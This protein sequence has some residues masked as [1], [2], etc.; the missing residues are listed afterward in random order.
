MATAISSPM[1]VP[2]AV[3]SSRTASRS[4][5]ASLRMR[6]AISLPGDVA[7]ATD[8][9]GELHAGGAGGPGHP[10]VGADVAVRVD[11]DDVRRPVLG[12]AE[13]HPSVVAQ[14]EG[15]EGADGGALDGSLGR[16]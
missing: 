1:N 10:G 5:G 2:P 12:D 11:V 6:I 4:G 9:L 16:R 7:D 8:E 13:V 3:R 15:P 14:L